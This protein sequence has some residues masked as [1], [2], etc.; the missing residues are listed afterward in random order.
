MSQ[1]RNI[2]LQD[3]LVSLQLN[4]V[5]SESQYCTLYG[6]RIEKPFNNMTAEFS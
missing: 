5:N 2:T 1:E 6:N 4:K 3:A